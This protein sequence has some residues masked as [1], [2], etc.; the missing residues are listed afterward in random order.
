MPD[1]SHFKALPPPAG[2]VYNSTTL[3]LRAARTAGLI[4]Q[5][6]Y[7]QYRDWYIGL[8]MLNGQTDNL[9]THRLWARLWLPLGIERGER[10]EE[11][12]KP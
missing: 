3:K 10:R 4:T 6:E 5:A 9:I 11:K 8:T 2:R 1:T 12:I 7:Q